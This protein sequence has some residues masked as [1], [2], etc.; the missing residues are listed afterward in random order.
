[1]KVLCSIIPYYTSVKTNCIWQPWIK[2]GFFLMKVL[3]WQTFENTCNTALEKLTTCAQMVF[4]FTR[5]HSPLI[6]CKVQLLLS[7]VS[8]IICARDLIK[9]LKSIDRCASRLKREAQTWKLFATLRF[10]VFDKFWGIM[11]GMTKNG[12]NFS[13]MI[14]LKT[15]YWHITLLKI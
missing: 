2:Q 11:F 3:W 4:D 15:W 6:S 1:M 5:F 7:D 9:C 14:L 13:H 12:Q 10:P 8:C